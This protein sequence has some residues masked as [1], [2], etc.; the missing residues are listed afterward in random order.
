LS[1]VWNVLLRLMLRDVC[2]SDDNTFFT[3]HLNASLRVFAHR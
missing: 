1:D 3:W 2:F